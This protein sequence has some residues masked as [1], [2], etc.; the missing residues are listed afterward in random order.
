MLL[1]KDQTKKASKETAY[2]VAAATVARMSMREVGGENER[3][4]EG[5]GDRGN[6]VHERADC[7]PASPAVATTTSSL[8]SARSCIARLNRIVS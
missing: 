5:V 8:I 1:K 2:G 7:K 4:A 6:A 3:V